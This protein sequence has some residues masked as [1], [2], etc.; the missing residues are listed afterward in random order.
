MVTI[1]M[2]N[3][4]GKTYEIDEINVSWNAVPF[5]DG[6]IEA[7]LVR[8]DMCLNC[9]GLG[10]IRGNDCPECD[11]LGFERVFDRL[12]MNYEDYEVHL[13]NERQRRQLFERYET[14]SPRSLA[15]WWK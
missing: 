1:L 9:F 12:R 11:G 3:E 6:F 15:D 4:H 8:A 13:R 14:I 5:D 7:E 10:I 2:Y